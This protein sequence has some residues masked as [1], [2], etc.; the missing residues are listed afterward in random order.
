V[1]SK[2]FNRSADTLRHWEND[3]LKH[4]VS[5]RSNYAQ[6][7]V[8]DTWD[9]VRPEPTFTYIANTKDGAKARFMWQL[10]NTYLVKGIKTHR[11][12]GQSDKV[13]KAVNQQLQ[14]PANE[15]RG[16]SLI[17]KLYFDSSKRLRGHLKTYAGVYYLWRGENRH[18][19][20]IFEATETGRGETS[21]KERVSF[22][23]ERVVKARG[24]VRIQL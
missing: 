24:K 19:H 18:H 22:R 13:R 3:R 15:W 4:T 1:L 23:Q 9:K 12:K 14:K 20:G 7:A 10:P 5:T 21:A 16:G 11:H 8:T 17:C 6:C 2:L